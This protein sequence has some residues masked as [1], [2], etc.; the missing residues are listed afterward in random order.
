MLNSL[1]HHFISEGPEELQGLS[2]LSLD[3]RWTWSHFSDRLWESIDPEAWGRT[4]NPYYIMQ[5]VPRTLL[6]EM[7]KDKEFGILF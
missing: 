1:Y 5:S 3:L 6:M 2:E 7:A 4:R